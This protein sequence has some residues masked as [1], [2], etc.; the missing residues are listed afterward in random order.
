MTENTSDKLEFKLADHY[1]LPLVKQFFKKNGMRAQAPKGDIIYIATLDNQI[2]AALRLQPIQNCHLL[3]SMCVHQGLRKTGI[4]SALLN[5]LQ[6][7]LSKLCCYSF[8]YEHL[9]EFYSRANFHLCETDIVPQA[10]A[11]KFVRYIGNGK[12]LILMIHQP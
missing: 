2:V 5:F 12:K 7:E 8:P 6:A 11:G 3:R 1:T 9:A 10:I 4:G